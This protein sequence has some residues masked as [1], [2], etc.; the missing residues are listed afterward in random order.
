ML[1]TAALAAGLLFPAAANAAIPQ[2]FTTLPAPL[3]CTVQ[4]SGQRFCSGTITSWDGIPLDVNVGF[5]PASADDT[6]WP[7]IGLYH[8]WGGSKLSLTSADAQRVL[9]RGYAMFSIT[10]RR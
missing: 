1:T 10:D 5:P 3:S 6:K 7:V 4:A 2:V 8:G 9:T